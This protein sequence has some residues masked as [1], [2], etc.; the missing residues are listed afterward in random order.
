MFVVHILCS[1]GLRQRHWDKMNEIIGFST[2]PDSCTSLR[3]M[4]KYN[5]EPYLEQFEGISAGASKEYSLEK[6]MQKMEDDWDPI[7]F[8]TSLYRD[9]G[10]CVCLSVCLRERG[11]KRERERKRERGGE[12][13]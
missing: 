7:I 5:L 11:R 12:V 3:K 4:L 2:T 10:W 8:N 1:P 6:A 9:T 13:G